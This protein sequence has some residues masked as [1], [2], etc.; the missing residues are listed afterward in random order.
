M[1]KILAFFMAVLT[2]FSGLF[3]TTMRINV[4]S[5][6]KKQEIDGWGTSACWWSQKIDDAETRE[7]LAKMLYSEEGLGLN[8]YRYNVGGGVNPEHN[9]VDPNSSRSTESFYYFNE[10]T[11]KYEYDFTRDAN[12]QAFLDEALKYGCIDTVVLFANSPHYSMTISGEATGSYYGEGTTNLS[13][14]HYQDFVDYFLT[15][16]EYFIDKGVPVKYISPINEPQWDWGGDWVG[17]EGCHY[18]PNQVYDL[19]KLFSKGIDERGLDV[20]LSVPESGEI[21]DLTKTYFSSLK[22]DKDIYKNIGAFAYHSY[23]RD[24]RPIEKKDFGY[25]LEKNHYT[26]KKIEMSE[27]CELPCEHD[28][29]DVEGAVIMARIIANDMYYTGANSWTSWVAVNTTGIRED[30]AKISD[31][32]FYA[33]DNFDKIEM[34]QRYYAMAHFSKF[35]PAGSKMVS[36]TANTYP[37]AKDEWGN[38]YYLTNF[39]A[40]KTPDGKTVLVIANEDD[41]K[42]INL[43]VSAKNMTVYTTDEDHKLEVTYSGKAMKSIN[44]SHN[45]ITTVVFESN[46]NFDLPC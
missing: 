37:T 6:I 20:K 18:E 44:V 41:A 27:W 19:I 45:S 22:N 7:Y 35:V 4:N 32:M 16:T 24:T 29:N 38:E 5:T 12:A 8:I 42:K 13:E 11:G 2:F 36:A 30:G 34:A 26:D 43:S 1:G 33:D 28:V 3:G 23:W 39:A 9:R 15:I 21:G 25:W 31:A 40:F 46:S 14:E 17:Q 10:E